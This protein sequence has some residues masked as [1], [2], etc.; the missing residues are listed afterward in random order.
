M[1]ENATNSFWTGFK[2]DTDPTEG[3]GGI[4]AEIILSAG[5]QAFPGGDGAF[6][7]PVYLWCPPEALKENP[8]RQKAL[9]QARAVS[10]KPQWGVGILAFKD[11]AWKR[12]EDGTTWEKV[13][14]KEDRVEFYPKYESN[15]DDV[16]VAACAELSIEPTWQGIARLGW[17]DSPYHVDK[18]NAFLAQSGKTD[19]E[20]TD[21]EKSAN[22][23]KDRYQDKQIFPRVM[24]PIEVYANWDEAQEAMSGGL[25]EA[26]EDLPD[27]PEAW[28][29]DL[30]GWKSQIADIKD[31]VT[32]KGSPSKKLALITAWLETED[33]DGDTNAVVVEATAEQILEWWEV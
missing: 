10:G 25:S 20:T 2:Q 33:D 23:K 29:G 26:T 9:E 5:Y 11:Q 27:L 24:Y 16:L 7:R 32:L 4:F 8:D 3:G 21:G 14:W 22:G 31:K 19:A 15:F 6:Q 28:E 17:K 1:S 30:D 18:Y 13:T 12:G